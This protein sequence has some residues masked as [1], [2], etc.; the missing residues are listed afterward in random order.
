MEKLKGC[1]RFRCNLI[2]LEIPLIQF[3]YPSRLSSSLLLSSFCYCVFLLLPDEDTKCRKRSFVF[4]SLFNCK[5]IYIFIYKSI[6]DKKKKHKIHQTI[7]NGLSHCL[8]HTSLDGGRRKN[9]GFRRGVK[10]NETERQ[11][12]ERI[13][14]CIGQLHSDRTRVVRRKLW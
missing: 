7:R 5:F 6:K 8:L 9:W 12:W 2:I 11:K 4:L 3:S 13:S 14:G 10:L 1:M